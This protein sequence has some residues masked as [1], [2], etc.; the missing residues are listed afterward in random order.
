MQCFSVKKCHRR[1]GVVIHTYNPSSQ[2]AEA[3][4]RVQGQPGQ[5]F[6]NLSQNI[7]N[8]QTKSF[9]KFFKCCPVI[10]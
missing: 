4:L 8:K 6:V 1:L 9:K 3:E 2:E 5:Y 7:K 10:N